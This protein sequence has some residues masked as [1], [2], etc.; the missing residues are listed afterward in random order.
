M[1]SFEPDLFRPSHQFYGHEGLK[2][3]LVSRRYVSLAFISTIQ[4]LTFLGDKWLQMNPPLYIYSARPAKLASPIWPP[5]T[6]FPGMRSSIQSFLDQWSYL[7]QAGG[8]ELRRNREA[9]RPC[10][11][12]KPAT[13]AELV[14]KLHKESAQNVNS[15]A[16]SEVSSAAKWCCQCN[17][18]QGERE[19]E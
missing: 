15:R 1:P 16:E 6:S 13:R 3:G 5:L 19:L 14:E 2:I 18:W 8:K 9:L 17:S 4:Y 12:S 7:V 11:A 10:S